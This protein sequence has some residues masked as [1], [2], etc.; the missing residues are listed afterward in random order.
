MGRTAQADTPPAGFRCDAGPVLSNRTPLRN[1]RTKI[2]RGVPV[3]ILAI[4]SSST[5]GIGA[6]SP[7]ASYPAQLEQRL[8]A[9]WPGASVAV[10]N[11][12][13][14]GETAEQTLARL[15][16]DTLDNA[17]DLVLWQVGT[18]DALKG[19]GESRF[20]GLLHAGIAAA[21]ESGAMV[22]LVDPQFFPKIQ[23]SAAFERFVSA[24]QAIAAHEDVPVYSRFT[25][26]KR[27][28]ERNARDLLHALA[29]DQFHMN[30]VGYDC[31]AD[32]IAQDVK[33]MVGRVQ[34]VGL[35]VAQAPR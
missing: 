33:S 7:A 25:L 18:N 14:G 23:G 19:D 15:K 8:R 16:R 27:W 20:G 6:S 34:S 1:I 26:M 17:Y 11:A 4:G 32:G 13:V 9:A 10:I 12:G 28:S 30:D 31:L 2:E 35:P 29:P 22:M 24:I 5:E 3:R 21:R